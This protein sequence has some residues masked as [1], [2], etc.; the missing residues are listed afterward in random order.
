MGSEYGWG[1]REK[2][3]FS[4]QARCICVCMAWTVGLEILLSTLLS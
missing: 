3:L 1:M 2:S 4:I